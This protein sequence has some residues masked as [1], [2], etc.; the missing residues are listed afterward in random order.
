MM[1]FIKATLWSMFSLFMAGIGIY[2]A[3][4]WIKGIG[5]YWDWLDDPIAPEEI[6][7][8]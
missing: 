7:D 6:W 5:E 1:K 8:E 2:A 4:D 3:V